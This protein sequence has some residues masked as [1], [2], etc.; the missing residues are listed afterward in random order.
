MK[1]LRELTKAHGVSGNETAVA[2][3]IKKYMRPLCDEISEDITGNVIAHKKGGGKRIML[4]AHMDEVGVIVTY[5]DKNGFVRF[6]AVGGLDVR[7]LPYKRV[8]FENG[9]VGVIGCE[10]KNFAKKAEISALYIDIGAQSAEEAE[11]RVSVGDTAAFVGDMTVSG[12]TVISKTLDNRAGC[13]CLIKAMEI[14]DE[15]GCDNDI[16]CA[17][18]VQE[19]VGLRGAGTAAYGIEP[20]IALA[21]D[22]TDT[23][24]T[25]ECERMAVKL[26]GGAAV[27]LYDRSI[28]CHKSV[29][30]G[31]I[32][33]A[34]EN[35][36]PYQL[37][38]MTAGG[39]DAGAIHTSRSGV[40][41][42]G[43]S[44]PC[45][46]VHSPS[47]VASVSDMDAC[48]ELIAAF[49]REI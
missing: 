5:T 1:L 16:Y 8:K 2:E 18:T 7:T 34:R 23:G 48:A 14:L 25:P 39:T 44:I 10:E 45:R 22:V 46:Y 49:C 47:G 4:A 30:E 32:K 11:K 15:K 3:V 13:R 19:E 27:K 9:T 41:T 35:D 21:V 33:I 20:E 38:V 28:I 37:E 17:F 36:I 29:R 24:D 26:G 40:A 43:I 31:L 6:N 12:D 42:G